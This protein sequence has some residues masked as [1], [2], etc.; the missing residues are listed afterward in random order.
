MKLN[1]TAKTK[2]FSL[3]ELLVVIAVIGI[4]AAIAIPTISGITDS[5]D[6]GAAKRNAQNLASVHANAVAA[7]VTFSGGDTAAVILEL[8]SG[9]T[10]TGEVFDGTVFQVPNLT[11][12]EQGD[13]AAYLNLANGILYYDTDITD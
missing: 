9:K 10:A 4:I 8:V 2:G 1:K 6:T 3:V 11:T 12:E 7:G 13:A 5:A